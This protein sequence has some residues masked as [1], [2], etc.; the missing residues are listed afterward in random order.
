MYKRQVYE[1]DL[2]VSFGMSEPQS[3]EQAET[4]EFAISPAVAYTDGQKVAAFIW[5]CDVGGSLTMIPLAEEYVLGG[6]EPEPV[7]YSASW[8]FDDIAVGT[9]YANG[10]TAANANGDAL[11]VGVAEKDTVNPTI[12][13]R[14]TGDN[15]L[16][17]NDST[18][19]GSAK[20]D[21]WT[22]TAET[23]FELSLIHI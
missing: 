2:L 4:V 22:Y 3:Y 11:T 21:S 5:S 18:E 20:Q 12:K 16:E 13:E 15:Y 14:T 7:E 9:T 19:D 8:S 17:F 6:S 1:G 10:E 23:P